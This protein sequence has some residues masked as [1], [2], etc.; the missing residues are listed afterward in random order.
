MKKYVVHCVGD[1]DRF[2]T[3]CQPDLPRVRWDDNTDERHM[4]TPASRVIRSRDTE[5]FKNGRTFVS[6]KNE[7][8][9]MRFCQDCANHPDL[10]LLLLGGV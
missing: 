1:D 4:V 5:E 3:L 2:T 9:S 7:N 8:L 6:E 10:E